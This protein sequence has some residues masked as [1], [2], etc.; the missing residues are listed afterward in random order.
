VVIITI[1]I[2]LPTN[3][4]NHFLTF[5]QEFVNKT[6]MLPQA[7]SDN[8]TVTNLPSATTK[9]GQT[10]NTVPAIKIIMPK[11]GQ[12]V[13]IASKDFTIYGTSSDAILNDC[14]VSVIVNSI[15]PY[16]KAAARADNGSNDYSS[17]S[18]K[19]NPLY[20][21]IKEGSNKITAK[22]TCIGIPNNL[23]KWTSVNVTGIKTN[24]TKAS[25]NPNITGYE[26]LQ[27][28]TTALST[29]KT[30]KGEQ[31]PSLQNQYESAKTFQNNITSQNYAPISPAK[32]SSKNI[33]TALL[34]RTINEPLQIL[35]DV[36]KN[37]IT[38]GDIQTITVTVH[39]SA[40]PDSIVQGA[41]VS[42]QVID[43]SSSSLSN[44]SASL[45]KEQFD[46][47]TDNNGQVS[48]SWIVS[49]N[50]KSDKTF[51]VGVE[52]S[53]GNHAKSASITFTVKPSSNYNDNNFILAQADRNFTEGLSSG[54]NK[55]TQSILKEV[56]KGLGNSLR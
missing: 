47:S 20:T 11:S 39:G 18:Y 3:I 38:A 24:N 42:G 34:P 35:I 50:V 22:I 28:S 49:D 9:H 4:S 30:Q 32:S 16:Q 1:G 52:A 26:K 31:Q 43:L 36:G 27:S 54:V 8:K 5:A 15:K 10:A 51:K 25:V 48:Y 37:P 19:L 12:E 13:P 14:G 46:E 44:S 55:F 6:A 56:R 2:F 21:T 53:K 45:I 33:T 29:S 7:N 17:W 40:S 41:K 23:T